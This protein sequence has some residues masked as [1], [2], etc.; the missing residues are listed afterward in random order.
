MPEWYP[1][2]QSKPQLSEEAVLAELNRRAGYTQG[3]VRII[4]PKTVKSPIAPATVK[5]QPS[6]F[7]G[8]LT[9][10]KKSGRFG[11]TG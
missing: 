4:D 7:I 5:F 3:E 1:G 9:N 6:K 10:R 8:H 2:Y 11:R